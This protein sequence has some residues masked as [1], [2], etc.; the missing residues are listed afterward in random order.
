MWFNVHTCVSGRIQLCWSGQISWFVSQWPTNVAPPLQLIT[1]YHYSHKEHDLQCHLLVLKIT[2][3]LPCIVFV[4]PSLFHSD[5][6]MLTYDNKPH[7]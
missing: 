7:V 1:E 3:H 6:A 5:A 2:N 4:M